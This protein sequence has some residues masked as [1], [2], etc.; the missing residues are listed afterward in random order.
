MGAGSN[1]ADEF[2]GSHASD[3]IWVRYGDDFVVYHRHSAK[4]HLLNLAGYRLLTEILQQPVTTLEIAARLANDCGDDAPPD[5]VAVREMLL[6]FEHLGL[7]YR[8]VPAK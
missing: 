2:W 4:T 7:V 5:E 1:P 3:C 6:R 8:S